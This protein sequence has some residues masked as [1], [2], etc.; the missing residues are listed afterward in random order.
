MYNVVNDRVTNYARRVV[1][2]E[3]VAGKLHILACQ[4]HLNDL[5]R[6]N[7]KEFPY[8]YDPAKAQEILDYAESLTIAEGH[9]PKPVKLLDCQA[10]DLGCTFGWFK[11]TNGKRRFRRRYKS[12][13]RQNGKTFENGIMGTYVAGFG[14]YNHGKLFT[15]ATKKRQARL[16]WEEMSKFISI[17]EDLGELFKVKDY[18]SVI[19]ALETSCTIEAL[20]KEAGL[21]DGFRSIFSSIDRV[22]CRF[23]IGQ[24]RWK[25]KVGKCSKLT[26]IDFYV[27]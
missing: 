4:R 26:N 1:N 10:F 24:N 18:K 8:Y 14:G 11:V 21:E 7:T 16:A 27:L 6:Q 17:D 3:V 2:G 19:E 22:I 25:S 13:A 15:V 20:S 12:I 9:E 23:K 5:E